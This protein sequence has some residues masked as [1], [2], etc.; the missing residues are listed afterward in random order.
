MLKLVKIFFKLIGVVFILIGC[1]V[2]GF[3]ILASLQG[4][5]GLGGVIGGGLYMAL[6]VSIIVMNKKGYSW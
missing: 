6:G 2:T 1:V 4:P 3:G 5:Y